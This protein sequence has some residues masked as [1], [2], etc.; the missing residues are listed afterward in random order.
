[1]LR[2]ACSWLDRAVR[3]LCRRLPQECSPVNPPKSIHSV[4]RLTTTCCSFLRCSISLR[5]VNALSRFVIALV[6]VRE[7]LDKFLRLTDV[8]EVD[9][10]LRTTLTK[11]HGHQT[12]VKLAK[13]DCHVLHAGVAQNYV[14]R[15]RES[16]LV[17]F[18]VLWVGS[19]ESAYEHNF[20]GR[21]TDRSTGREGAKRMTWTGRRTER[22]TGRGG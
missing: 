15:R 5:V 19:A 14:D 9:L 1:M 3:F 2:A 17:T 12:P 10:A 4:C 16:H 20:V 21:R 13:F 18:L 8:F 7:S 22:T 6:L 11:E